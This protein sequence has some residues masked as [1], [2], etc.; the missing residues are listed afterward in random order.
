M[1]S[2]IKG[3]IGASKVVSFLI[4]REI[5]VFS[6][7]YCDNS[8]I[9]LIAHTSSGLKTIQVRTTDSTK[10]GTRAVLS[11]RSITPGTRKTPCKLSRI[12]NVD[13]FA[14]YLMDRDMLI[15]IDSQEVSEYKSNVKFD[16]TGKSNRLRKA[17]DYLK[18]NF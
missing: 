15:F 5:P 2:K 18:P 3:G 17:S 1:H 8:E 13:I 9:D 14:L 16:L 7:L 4:E 11:L 12:Y 10:S 6:E